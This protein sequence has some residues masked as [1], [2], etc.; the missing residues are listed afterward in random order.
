MKK[1]IFNGETYTELESLCQA[2]VANFEDA[3]EQVNDRD[4]AAS[5][6]FYKRPVWAVGVNFSS[7]TRTI[8]SWE[9]REMKKG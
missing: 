6:A 9:I 4:Y 1:Y 8:E 2:F 7:T 3:V 5:F